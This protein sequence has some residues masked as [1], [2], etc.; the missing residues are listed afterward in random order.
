[1]GEIKISGL[2]AVPSTIDGTELLALVQDSGGV[3]DT[4]KATVT[5]LRP[6]LE[7]NLST[8]APTWTTDGVLRAGHDIIAGYVD[9]GASTDGGGTIGLTLNDGYGNANITFNHTGGIPDRSGSSARITSTVDSNQELLAFQLKGDTIG[10][11]VTALTSVLELRED[12]ISLLKPTSLSDNSIGI[13]TSSL[14]N[15]GFVDNAIAAEA[16]ARN[17]A[18]A[19]TLSSADANAQGFVSAEEAARIAADVVV[20]GAVDALEIVVD[21]K[22]GEAE[23]NSTHFTFS[24]NQLNLNQ[25]A[26]NQIV[27]NFNTTSN[28]TAASLRLTNTGDASITSTTHAF[29]V[30][31]TSGDNIIIDNNEIMARNNGAVDTLHLNNNGGNVYVGG[32]L[33][34]SSGTSINEFSTDTSLS[35]NSDNA[36]PTEKAVKAYVDANS[37][38]DFSYNASTKT[39]TIS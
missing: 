36:V 27:N 9:S 35:G 8:G 10:N 34:C 1:M 7:D 31:A 18:D 6:A 3:L 26:G 23:I 12:S 20:Q 24:N 2:T 25:L 33:Q 30:G 19:A 17:A 13:S 16:A 22:I 5:N 32:T 29:Q 28:I 14:V 21:G 38:A 39:L 15:R 11:S 4:F 37:G